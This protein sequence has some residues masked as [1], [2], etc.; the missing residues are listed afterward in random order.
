MTNKLIKKSLA[1][2]LTGVIAGCMFLTG[3]P[4]ASAESST[5][6]G[7]AAHCLR[8]YREDWTYV[9]GGTS[10]GAVDCSGL[11]ASYNGVGGIRF[12]MLASCQ[13]D[14]RAWGYVSNGVPN[15]HGLGLHSPGHVGV[16]IGSGMAVDARDVGIDMC[17]QNV[18][19]RPW[20]EWFMISGVSYPYQGWVLLDGESFYY[21]DGE[22]LTN[23][24]RKYLQ[25]TG[26]RDLYFRQ[27]RCFGYRT[28]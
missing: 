24:S 20:V 16:Y 13:N 15:I 23:T 1:L 28:A 14:G 6:I 5:N 8:A 10:Y 22:Y 11:I 26:R 7:L 18:Y 27:R 9:W 4:M 12:D 25:N 17:Y 21:E 3:A 2:V 19:S